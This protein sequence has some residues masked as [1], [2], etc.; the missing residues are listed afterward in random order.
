MNG[1]AINR[2]WVLR[3]RPEGEVTASHFELRQGAVPEPAAGQVLIRVRMISIDPAN[4]AW[5]FPTATYK[6]PVEP[7]QTMHGFGLGE[8]VTSNAEGFV[9]GDIVEGM[10]GWQEYAAVS[11]SEL[12]VR[13]PGTPAE[14][15][16]GVLGIT[17]L[18]ALYGL[19]EIGRPRRGETVVVSAAAGA[20]GT[21][22]AQIAKI[23]GCRVVGIAGGPEKCQWLVDE[24]GLD[25]AV[26]YKAGEL[27]KALKRACPN[28]VDV[29]FDNTGGDALAA[30]LS[31][32]NPHGRIIC[33]GN[34]SQYNTD[35]PAPGPAGVPGLLVTKR[36]RMEGFIVLDHLAQRD[37]MEATLQ[38]WLDDGRLKTF[39][40]VVDGL[41]KAPESLVQMFRG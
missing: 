17:G 19:R 11:A 10:L 41:E 21:I 13:R 9:A 16:M 15:A 38:G 36:I 6:A 27:R 20:V 4:R 14:H 5:M 24:L 8:V 29:Y 34:L 12:S 40:T 1:S 7:G 3:E 2:H 32:M 31:A 18:T 23:E 39:E 26:D 37:Q 22:A 35:R 25:A 28:G 30:A 33:C